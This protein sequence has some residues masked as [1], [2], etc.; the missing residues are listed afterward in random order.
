MARAGRGPVVRASLHRWVY[1][2]L[3]AALAVAFV[4]VLAWP[5][6]LLRRALPAPAAV[7][8]CAAV[9]LLPVALVGTMGEVRS[10][11]GAAAAA[12]LT[13]GAPARPGP[14]RRG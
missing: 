13:P 14:G 8:A 12:L 11:E 7:P 4:L 9:L 10:V 6:E 1:L 3:G 5:V 2:L